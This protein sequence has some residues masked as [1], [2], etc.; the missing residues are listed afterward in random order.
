MTRPS[1]SL[2]ASA[3]T[4]K[5]A[6]PRRLPAYGD[7]HIPPGEYN[8]YVVGVET[9]AHCRNWEPRV[10]VLW[11]IADAGFMG[12]VV[13]AYY[14]VLSLSGRPRRNGRFKV[15]TK[16]RLYRELARMLNRRPPVDHVPID[17]VTDRL[18]RIVV[19]DAKH[20]MEQRPLGCAIY[21]V[22]EWVKGPT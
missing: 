15:G 19:R 10:V 18:Y 7:A 20:D 5:R 22:V 14:R 11:A 9:W 12:T 21:S 8:A 2:D 6:H 17:E 4:V 13:P 16:S 1:E 3:T